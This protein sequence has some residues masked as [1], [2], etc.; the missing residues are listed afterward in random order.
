MNKQM[1]N[2]SDG[3]H[4]IVKRIP[5]GQVIDQYKALTIP[6]CGEYVGGWHKSAVVQHV[7]HVIEGGQLVRVEL[8]CIDRLTGAMCEAAKGKTPTVVEGAA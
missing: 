4:I 5:D 8:E 7:R 6:R 2:W 3:V 1:N